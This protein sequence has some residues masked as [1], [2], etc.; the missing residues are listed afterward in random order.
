MP[1]GRR[2][3]ATRRDDAVSNA[4]IIRQTPGHREFLVVR[5][6]MG[7]SRENKALRA[8][9]KCNFTVRFVTFFIGR[10]LMFNYRAADLFFIISHCSI[11]GSETWYWNSQKLPFV[12]ICY[13]IF[14]GNFVHFLPSLSEIRNAS[15]SS[16]VMRHF[17]LGL[18]KVY[19]ILRRSYIFFKCRICYAYTV[20]VKSVRANFFGSELTNDTL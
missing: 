6:D 2:N 12:G 17:Y 11:P 20:A 4:Q 1:I 18:T 13:F 10:R 15:P 8:W 16:L 7:I 14:R 3:V 5:S 9:G 19:F